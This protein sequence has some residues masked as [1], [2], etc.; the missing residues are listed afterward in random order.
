[1]RLYIMHKF[2][3]L[4]LFTLLSCINCSAKD[5]FREVVDYLY[6]KTKRGS[7]SADIQK[8]FIE[9]LHNKLTQEITN[10]VLKRE[11]SDQFF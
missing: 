9:N 4:I 10:S 6:F 2:F 8:L 3:L 11:P 5:S 1:M 7:L